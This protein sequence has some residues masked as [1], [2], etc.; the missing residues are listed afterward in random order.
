MNLWTT[1]S[2]A[3]EQ[4]N[5]RKLFASLRVEA[6]EY[7][8]FLA[9]AEN[10]SDFG[11]RMALI[12]PELD[13]IVRSATKDGATYLTARAELEESFVRDFE[14][15]ASERFNTDNRGVR[16]VGKGRTPPKSFKDPVSC[17]SCG[18][19]WDDAHT[20]SVTPAPSARCPFEYMRGH[21]SS[22]TAAEKCTVCGKPATKYV[23]GQEGY[24][25][26]GHHVC[27]TH[28]N[29]FSKSAEYHYVKPA[30]GGKYKIIQ[31]GTGK[32]LST[33]DS[34]EEAESAFRAME[35]HMHGARDTSYNRPVECHYCGEK[36][37]KGPGAH[38]SNGWTDKGGSKNCSGGHDPHVPWLDEGSPSREGSKRED[39]ERD[40]AHMV[41][42][43]C[44]GCGEPKNKQD[45]KVVQR[46]LGSPEKWHKECYQMYN[47]RLK[48]NP[49]ADKYHGAS[50]HST[51]ADDTAVE[52]Y[53]RG[54]GEVRLDRNGF[55]GRCTAPNCG[56]VGE[57][58]HGKY[59]ARGD[60]LK[61][62]DLPDN[63]PSD[64]S[65]AANKSGAR[66]TADGACSY[67]VDHVKEGDKCPQCGFSA[68]EAFDSF[69]QRPDRDDWVLSSYHSATKKGDVRVAGKGAYVTDAHNSSVRIDVSAGTKATAEQGYQTFMGTSVYDWSVEGQSGDGWQLGGDWS[70]SKTGSK[71]SAHDPIAYTYE[72]DIHCPE[73]AEKRFGPGAHGTDREGNE[74]GAVAPWDET[75]PEGEHCGTCGKEIAPAYHAGSKTAE[76]FGDQYYDPNGKP[77]SQCGRGMDSLSEFPG[78]RCI[79][80]HA[81]S[82]EGRAMPTADELSRMWGGP[83]VVGA[84]KVYCPCGSCGKPCEVVGKIASRYECDECRGR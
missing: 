79:S 70:D 10:K 64:G 24:S 56:W 49:S 55:Y 18:R 20:T 47:R 76:T 1:A 32:T 17:G 12:S 82:P 42:S 43:V 66:H 69:Q 22:K 54:D 4:V 84:K 7:W 38:G 33:H 78:D 28:A 67:C 72:A 39:A 21:S 35:M 59:E 74:V 3:T 45:G 75:S 46:D 15:I 61:H 77:C 68:R 40:S 62:L 11:N 26:S 37:T 48:S 41:G 8:P 58:R 13:R 83:G 52:T 50:L 2:E 23:G 60:V 80:C 19:T 6:V 5:H 16:Y 81:N 44:R 25:A 36:L 27:D 31:K 14:V 71:T 9:E 73:C 63:T 34:K 65:P 57:T 51:A 53:N 29:H 30:G